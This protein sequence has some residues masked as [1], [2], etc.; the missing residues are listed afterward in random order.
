MTILMITLTVLTAIL[1]VWAFFDISRSRFENPLM[2]WLW[3]ILILIFPILGSIIYFQFGKKHTK[4]PKKF[5]P[6]FSKSSE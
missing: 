4:D 3:I 5:N 6:D 1:W 2:K